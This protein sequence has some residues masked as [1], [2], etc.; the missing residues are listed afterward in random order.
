M[1]A[2][3]RINE[4]EKNVLYKKVGKKYTQAHDICILDGLGEGWWLVKVAPSVKS[5]YSRVFPAKAEL[6]AA[7]ID[8]QEQLIKI[9]REASEAKPKQGVKLTLQAKADWD[10]LVSRNGEEFSTIYYPSFQ[11][12]AEKIVNAL[13]N[14]DS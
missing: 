4:K 14:Y 7:A 9:I 6:R 5:I 13:V 11:E 2:Y 1:T 10:T 3:E 8:K 12:N